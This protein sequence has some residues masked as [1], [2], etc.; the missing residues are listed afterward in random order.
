M[1][2]SISI[3]L[4]MMTNMNKWPLRFEWRS[5]SGYVSDVHTVSSCS[6][7]H[8]PFFIIVVVVVVVVFILILFL[9]L[10]L[11]ACSGSEFIF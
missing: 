11:F 4:L 6:V 1:D 7:G 3:F 2:K 5:D 8:F 10:G 9:R